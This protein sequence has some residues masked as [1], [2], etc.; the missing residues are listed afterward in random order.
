MYAL[1]ESPVDL[2]RVVVDADRVKVL[3]G[4]A[5]ERLVVR[6]RRHPAVAEQEVVGIARAERL[7]DHTVVLLDEILRERLGRLPGRRERALRRPT[8]VKRRHGAD[9][10]LERLFV[11]KE[12][13]DQKG[14]LRI[15]THGIERLLHG[16]H[17][18]RVERIEHPA[19]G[20]DLLDAPERELPHVRE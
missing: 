3:P 17:R 1:D 11:V 7:L 20:R 14:I 10:R 5:A 18:L 4:D 15:R 8:V 12:V 13:A 19:H 16:L 9:D 6:C 2:S